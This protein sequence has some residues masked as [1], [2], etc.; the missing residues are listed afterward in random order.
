MGLAAYGKNKKYTDYIEDE[1]L[2]HIDGKLPNVSI[3]KNDINNITNNVNKENYNY[4]ADYSYRVQKQTEKMVAKLIKKCKN[5]NVCITGGYGLNVV[6]NAKF[7]KE[8]HTLV[9]SKHDDIRVKLEGG[10]NTR[11]P[12][13]FTDIGVLIKGRD[14]QI[15]NLITDVTVYGDDKTYYLSL[16]LGGTVTFFNAGVGTI[17][18]ENQFKAGRFTDKRAKQILGMFGIDEKKFIDI[19]EK[20]DKKNAR[21]IVPKISEDVTRKV[22]LRAL[23]QLLVTGIGYGYYM[24]HKKGKKVEFYEMTRRRMMDSAKVKKVTVLYPKPGSAKRI[25]IEVVTKLYI[26]KINIRNKQGKLYPSHIMCDYKPNPDA[27]K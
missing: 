26:F 15:G 19:F 12:L 20:Y 8:F 3:R 4:Y 1:D 11:R 16:K 18:T 10:A 13:Q 5:K 21:K 27:V 7:I 14:L 22:N 9:L 25:D 17:F 6:A 24:V 23:L 2:T